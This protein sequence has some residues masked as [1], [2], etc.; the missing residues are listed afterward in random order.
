[1]SNKNVCMTAEHNNFLTVISK[2]VALQYQTNGKLA[3]MQFPIPFLRVAI[4]NIFSDWVI[5]WEWLKLAGWQ[6]RSGN[7]LLRFPAARKSVRKTRDI[8]A[9]SSA[10]STKI[11]LLIQTHAQSVIREF[12]ITTTATATGTSLNKRFNEQNNGCARAL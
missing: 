7:E 5:W 4:I 8:I 12:K 2:E 11:L 10:Q 1:M 3:K 9:W 6:S